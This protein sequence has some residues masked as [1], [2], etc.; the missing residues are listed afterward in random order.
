MYTS[1]TTAVANVKMNFYF[2][3]LLPSNASSLVIERIHLLRMWLMTYI[4]GLMD[5]THDNI[6][7]LFDHILYYI[8]NALL[9]VMILFDGIVD[10][11]EAANYHF[12]L[13]QKLFAHGTFSNIN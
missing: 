10:T 4:F 1:L 5:L 3:N 12:H 8:M 2:H 7:V 13:A 11:F 6:L 9:L